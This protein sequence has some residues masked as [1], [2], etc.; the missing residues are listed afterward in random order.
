MR[1]FKILLP[2]FLIFSAHAVQKIKIA[3]L[4][5]DG[6]TWS[7]NLKKMSKEIFMAT[8]NEVEIKIFF[9]G[10][11]GDEPDVLRK[12]QIGQIGG[13][14][15]TG[16]TL[17]TLA[18]D[19]RAIEIPFNFKNDALKALKT[20][21]KIEGN[22]NEEFR[23]KGF[24]NLGFFEIG[25][26]YLVSNKKV[27]NFKDLKGIKIW[28]WQGDDLV[29]ALVESMNLVSVPLALPDVHT[30][31]STGVIDAAY[32]SPLGILALGWQN[33]IKFLVDLP[34]AYSV[35][36]LLISLEEWKK[37]TPAYQ[38]IITEIAH[39]YIDLSNASTGK[40]NEMALKTLKE[41]GIQ[42]V[43]LPPEDIAQSIVIRNKV[44]EKIKNRL[45]SAQMIKTLEDHIKN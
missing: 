40:E 16:R 7:N 38:K 12:I 27:S 20:L 1:F 45:V 6:T 8:Q 28:S 13:S 42:F 2:F 3:V 15:F 32:S 24:E 4:A 11:M 41:S 26:V 33:K 18:P 14:V 19:S 17:G 22:F 44:I 37:I 31:L 10:A 23:R 29:A 5:P 36:A 43:S 25:M 35:A 34:V 9:G 21:K 30:S 39:K